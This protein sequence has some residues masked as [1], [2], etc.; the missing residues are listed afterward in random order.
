MKSPAALLSPKTAVSE[1]IKLAKSLGILVE[2]FGSNT[3][4]DGA[5]VVTTE[6][7]RRDNFPF[8]YDKETRVVTVPGIYVDF[9]RWKYIPPQTIAG[10]PNANGDAWLRIALP[11]SFDAMPDFWSTV[12]IGTPTLEWVDNEDADPA[13]PGTAD[14]VRN[15]DGTI[16]YSY[17][18]HV[19]DPTEPTEEEPVIKQMA[20]S[21]LTTGIVRGFPAL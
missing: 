1:V 16:F 14:F 7:I 17:I 8:K 12:S 20:V 11:V 4:P 3:T 9:A 15:D 19:F 5:R 2:G 21:T 13:P 6:F 18:I 10:G